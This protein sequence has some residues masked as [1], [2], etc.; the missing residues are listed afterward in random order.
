MNP[1][2][3]AL[4]AE[5]QAGASSGFPW[6][7]AKVHA[8]SQ[9]ES[10]VESQAELQAGLPAAR[11]LAQPAAAARHAEAQR[12]RDLLAVLLAPQAVVEPDS[13]LGLLQQGAAWRAG[14]AAYRG[15]GLA[16]ATN[17][18]RLQCPTVLAM[19][20]EQAFDAICARHWHSRPPRCGD[21]AWVGEDFALTLAEQ[22]D[23]RPWPWLADCARLD[24]ALWQVQFEPPAA[25]AAPDLQ[26]LAEGD[27]A[28]LQLR[29]APG[30]RRLQSPWA[31]VTLRHLHRQP[32]TDAAALRIALQQPGETAWVWREGLQEQCLA[33]APEQDAWLHAL[34]RCASLDAAIDAAPPTFD[35]A[36]WLRDAVRHGWLDAVVP[37]HGR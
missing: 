19:L 16:H 18:L 22:D 25:F 17:A 1:L 10:H 29:L 7:Q 31:I 6:L 35:L 20:G 24:L 34:Q 13:S 3:T 15:N 4:A 26:R 30:T 8:E 14:L 37:L 27:P 12:Q 2:A 28:H 32:A 23:L 33:L 11:Q 9:A 21:L 36:A 5:L